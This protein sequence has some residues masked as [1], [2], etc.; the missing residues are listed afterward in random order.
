VCQIRRDQQA[1]D[2]GQHGSVTCHGKL[3]Y[4]AD[5]RSL[6]AGLKTRPPL[7]SGYTQK[8]KFHLLC[9][10]MA[11][12]GMTRT[13]CRACRECGAVLVPTWRTTKKQ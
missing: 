13:T 11:R 3:L 2:L 12:H 6:A 4:I 10:A 7:S 5:E 9:Y 8:P 1:G